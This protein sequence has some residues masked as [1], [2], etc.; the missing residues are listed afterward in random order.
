MRGCGEHGCTRPVARSITWRN[1]SSA[2]ERWPAR[3][4]AEPR[5]TS[6]RA[7]SSLAGEPA[8]VA[9]AWV[10]EAMPSCPPW[11]R[12]R[13]RRATPMAEAAPKCWGKA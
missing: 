10:S 3:R 2:W 6:A 4:S 5:S 7:C 8:R 13:V 11:A 9:T 12:P 1:G